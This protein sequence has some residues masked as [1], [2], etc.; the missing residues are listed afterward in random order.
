MS[1]TCNSLEDQIGTALKDNPYLFGRT[2]RVETHEGTVTLRGSVR[3]YYQKQMAQE[4]VRHIDGV[5]EIL[6]D[7]EVAHTG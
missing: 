5:A 3:T 6:N 2:L 7:L 1:Q 4:A